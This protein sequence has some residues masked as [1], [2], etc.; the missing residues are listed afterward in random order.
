MVNSRKRGI[1]F[2]IFGLLVLAIGILIGFFG[3]PLNLFKQPLPQPFSVDLWAVILVS[4]LGLLCL[5]LGFDDLGVF[6]KKIQKSDV[7]SARDIV[8]GQV[9]D[10]NRELEELAEKKKVI[11]KKKDIIEKEESLVDQQIEEHSKVYRA[12]IEMLN[13]GKWEDVQR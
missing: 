4:I 9:K 10:L 5:L 11:T 3:I 7:K 12:L 2:V 6:N 8:L 1:F 13:K